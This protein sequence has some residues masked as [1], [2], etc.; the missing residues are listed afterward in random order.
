MAEAL[1]DF[2]GSAVAETVDAT[3][4][5]G[6]FRTAIKTLYR[7]VDAACADLGI[8]KQQLTVWSLKGSP[9][10]RVAWLLRS[11]LERR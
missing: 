7:T 1:D 9:A 8:T 5:A 2:D 11:K 10:E 6:D 3:M 4:T